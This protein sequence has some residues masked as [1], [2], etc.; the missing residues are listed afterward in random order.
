MSKLNISYNKKFIFLRRIVIL[1]LVRNNFYIMLE[2]VFLMNEK[3][4]DKLIENTL[5][6]FAKKENI[7]SINM[8]M[9]NAP[10]L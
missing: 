10:I 5:K 9:I 1:F 8:Q 6:H 3:L 7:S 2:D 4:M